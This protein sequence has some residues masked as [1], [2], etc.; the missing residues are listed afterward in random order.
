MWSFYGVRHNGYGSYGHGFCLKDDTKPTTGILNGSDCVEMDTGKV[1]F[2]DE[3]NGEWLEWGAEEETPDAN[4]SMV[5]PG[6]LSSLF[7]QGEQPGIVTPGE[8]D[9]MDTGPVE[10]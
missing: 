1:Y 7:D 4:L 2:L 3:E 8:F 5:N 9:M 10:A 6:M